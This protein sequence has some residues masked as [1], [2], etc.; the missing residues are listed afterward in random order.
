M[1]GLLRQLD[2]WAAETEPV[3]GVALAALTDSA[4]T[5]NALADPDA[6]IRYTRLRFDAQSERLQRLV[7]RLSEDQTPSLHCA[8]VDQR[9]VVASG[10]WSYARQAGVYLPDELAE[11]VEAGR[12]DEAWHAREAL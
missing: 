11:L 8:P 2:A 10:V 6:V 9:T 7:A 1:S 12:I 5:A 3:S 4:T